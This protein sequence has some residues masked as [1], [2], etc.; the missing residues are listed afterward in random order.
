MIPTTWI[1]HHRDDGELIGYL[2][3]VADDAYL[4]VTLFGHPLADEPGE[5]WWAADELERHGLSY[6]AET[7]ELLDDDGT[8]S[9]VLITEC[10]PQTVVV[11]NAEFA[12]VVGRPPA[13]IGAPTR[14]PVPTDRLRPARR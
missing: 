14:L 11:A 13:D 5:Q 10:S 4:P 8:W 6:L 12:Q 9:R 7:W 3:P 2:T 1:A